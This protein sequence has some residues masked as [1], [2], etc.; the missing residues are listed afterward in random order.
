MI[1][2][3]GFAHTPDNNS[4]NYDTKRQFTINGE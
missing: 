1:G 2:L 4:V 3:D